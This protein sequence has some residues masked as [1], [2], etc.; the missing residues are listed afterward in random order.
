MAGMI[1]CLALWPT[2]DMTH[3]DRLTMLGIA[4]FIIFVAQKMIIITSCKNI[5]QN[6]TLEA[7][8]MNDNQFMSNWGYFLENFTALTS[9]VQVNGFPPILFFFFWFAKRCFDQYFQLTYIT[10]TSTYGTSY[11]VKSPLIK[12][13]VWMM[14]NTDNVESSL[15]LPFIVC[16][17]YVQVEFCYK[18]HIG[19]AAVVLVELCSLWSVFSKWIIY[20][21]HIA[22]YRVIVYCHVTGSTMGC[23][24][25]VTSIGV[26]GWECDC[27]L[28]HNWASRQ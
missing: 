18:L 9:E 24:L 15:Q 20:N 26:A 3:F 27:Q 25:R 23:S 21:E 1:D 16:E 4:F 8:C 12:Y 2:S 14:M 22:L 10:N 11:R 28:T 7:K 13:E 5:S 19:R 6:N 17:K